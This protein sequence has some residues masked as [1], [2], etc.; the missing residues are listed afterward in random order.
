M[1]PMKYVAVSISIFMHEKINVV[2][3]GWMI[4]LA[5]NV[6]LTVQ[7]KNLLPI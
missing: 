6:M 5:E 3:P 4:A 2:V 1:K 7:F